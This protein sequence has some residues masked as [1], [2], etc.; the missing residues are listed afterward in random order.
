MARLYALR[1]WLAFRMVSF[2]RPAG[3]RPGF[4][5]GA[6]PAGRERLTRSRYP[7]ARRHNPS[8]PSAVGHRGGRP[9]PGAPPEGARSGYAWRTS[10]R[11]PAWTGVVS[12]TASRATVPAIGAVIA[13]SIFIASM[14][15]TTSPA[16]TSSP[17]AARRVTE[18]SKGAATWP[19]SPG[20]ARS[21]GGASDTTDLSRTESVRSCPFTVQMTCRTPASSMSPTASSPAR[22]RTPGSRSNATSCPARSPKRNGP[23]GRTDRSP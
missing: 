8:R 6:S 21:T 10:R 4:C 14:V 13:A 20:S 7:A 2:A 1:A 16:A 17:L 5:P 12:G 11:S 19:G 9:P 3:A 22:T 15:A 18:P 23:V